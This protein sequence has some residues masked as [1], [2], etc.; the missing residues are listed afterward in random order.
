MHGAHAAAHD[1]GRTE[2]HE[3]LADDDA[4]QIRC[5]DHQ[6]RDQRQREA[7]REPEDDGGRAE[8]EHRAEQDGA[9]VVLDRPAGQHQ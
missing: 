9:G 8:E 7:R 4:Q 1:V 6:E 3:G 2:L 5:A